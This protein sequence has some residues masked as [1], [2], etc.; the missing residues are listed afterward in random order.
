MK[1]KGEGEKE[2]KMSKMFRA[3][4]TGNINKVAHLLDEGAN[5]T[6]EFREAAFWGA[7]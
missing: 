5:P 3:I 6:R 4:R 1:I 2:S 7:A